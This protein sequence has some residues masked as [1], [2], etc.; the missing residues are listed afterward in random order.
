MKYIIITAD[1]Y[2]M[3]ESVNRA[4]EEC[5]ESGLIKSTNIMVNMDFAEECISLR[6]KY[7]NISI[8]LHWNITCGSP[9]LEASK[10]PSLVDS[11]GKFNSRRVQTT[12]G[13]IKKK[14]LTDELIAQYEKFVS[15][16]GEPDYWNTHENV[17]MTF[18]YFNFFVD[19]ANSLGIKKFRS[20]ERIYTKF[21]PSTVNDYIWV[22]LNPIKSLISKSW[23]PSARKKGAKTPEGL[24]LYKNQLQKLDFK[25]SYKD[26]IWKNR[27]I[28][29]LIV[30]PA[31]SIDCKYFGNIGEAR[32][33]EYKLFSD[34]ELLRILND[35]GI[36]I[37]GFEVV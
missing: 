28:I 8:G 6:K 25:N 9:I 3:S 34:K 7:P 16:V 23:F 22:A 24:I 33:Y 36:Q 27:N 1:D 10:V 37:V 29:E 13:K 32:I 5:I 11:N 14:E 4:I 21:N 2:G 15:L 12:I 26:I 20:H 30:H 18:N 19:L 35:N 31:K 17:H